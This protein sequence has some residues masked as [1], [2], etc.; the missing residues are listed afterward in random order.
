MRWNLLVGVM[1]TGCG[2]VNWS[3]DARKVADST[4][5]LCQTMSCDD[6]DVCTA[7]SCRANACVHTPVN[8][9]HGQEVFPPVAQ[10]Q[11]FT[12]MMCVRAITIDASGAQG[13]IGTGGVGGMGAHVK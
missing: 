5:D 1:W 2:S 7:D 4:T 10:I 9:V 3:A 13:G 6:G 11:T 12:P 8:V